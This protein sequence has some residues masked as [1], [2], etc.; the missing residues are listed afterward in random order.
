MPLES[1]NPCTGE[2]IEQYDEHTDAQIEQAL[3]AAQRTALGWAETGLG[4]R[5]GLLSELAVRLRTEA[6]ELAALMTREMGKLQAEA[7]GE[8]HKCAWVCDY[9]A[10][11]APAFLADEPIETDAER[12]LVAYQPLGPWLAVM[13]WDFPFWQVFRCAAPAIAAG[14][15]VLLKHASNVPGCAHA[16]ERLLRDAGAPEGLFTTLLIAGSRAEAVVADDRVRGVSLTGSETAGRRVAAAAGAHLKPS[17][18]ELGGSDAFVVLEDA[19]IDRVAAVAAQ[20]RFLNGGQS[21][22]AAKRFIVVP[23]IADAFVEGFRAA[24]QALR[25]GDP[26][27]AGT[28]LPPMAR[29]DLREQLDAQVRASIDLGA[30]PITGAAPLERDGWFYAP[31]VLDRCAPGMPAYGDELFG[32]AAA[33]IRADDEADALRIANDSRF[34]LGGS[35]W[36]GDPDRG[37]AFARR[38]GCGCAFVN[39]MV[40]S[41]PRLPFSGIKASGYGRELG[42][43]GIRA[44]VNAQTL[45]IDRL[46]SRA[47]SAA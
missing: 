42:L 22:I 9:Y 30:R 8:L 1:I 39:G 24:A 29:S 15:P 44:F 34:G 3:A 19:D 21:C 32:P 45:W 14:D 23:E 4:E 17:V 46:A 28:S 18:L 25:P 11:H 6:D 13:P 20:A 37:E 16:I 31:T 40:K 27:E 38:L 35:V 41:D 26:M 36:T 43:M 2:P 5:T 47:G 7:R 33:I 12:S 10:E